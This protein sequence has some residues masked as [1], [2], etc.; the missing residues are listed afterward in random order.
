MSTRSD[1]FI[2]RVK[3]SF[4]SD[5]FD[6]RRET[7]YVEDFPDL[8]LHVSQHK[9]PAP[10][11]YALL[12]HEED[13]ESLAGSVVQAGTV[14]VYMSGISLEKWFKVFLERCRRGGVDAALDFDEDLPVLTVYRYFHPS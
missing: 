7:G 12:E 14:E 11:L 6:Y 4:M 8:R 2:S 3:I 13:P 9:A 1:T 10:G 5:D